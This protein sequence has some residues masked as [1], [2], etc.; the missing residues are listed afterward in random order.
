MY[1]YIWS[2]VELYNV[3]YIWQFY[4]YV[5]DVQVSAS[6]FVRL[7]GADGEQSSQHALA[8]GTTCGARLAGWQSNTQWEKDGNTYSNSLDF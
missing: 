4:V 3:A 5:H 1:L 6:M 7:M 8:M 2:Y